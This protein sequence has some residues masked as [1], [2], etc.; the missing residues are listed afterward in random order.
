[1]K[2]RVV[3]RPDFVIEYVGEDDTDT[4]RNV[5]ALIGVNETDTDF[6]KLVD[7]VPVTC[8]LVAKGVGLTEPDA[9]TVPDFS[10]DT[11]TV[12]VPVATDGVLLPLCEPYVS[13]GFTDLL[14]VRDVNTV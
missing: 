10:I 3:G 1:M 5:V 4:V 13:V 14:G 2:A 11:D 6:V 12:G 9:T 7:T 8:L